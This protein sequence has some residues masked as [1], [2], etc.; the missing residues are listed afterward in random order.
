MDIRKRG[1]SADSKQHSKGDPP[2]DSDAT[3]TR[4]APCI[5]VNLRRSNGW[6]G[7]KCSPSMTSWR[8]MRRYDGQHIDQG[9]FLCHSLPRASCVRP[10][11]VSRRASSTWASAPARRQGRGIEVAQANV[12]PRGPGRAA[13]RADTRP[14]RSRTYLRGGE[15]GPSSLGLRRTV[16]G[17]ST[18][19][20]AVRTGRRRRG[21]QSAS[22]S[23]EIRMP[24]V[25]TGRTGIEGMR[26]GRR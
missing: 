20:M 14:R 11:R 9:N 25:R 22:M 15:F 19:R 23:L 12:G 26:E 5:P 24:K 2:P 18:P 3:A 8:D 1:G 4:P 17:P 13:A 6:R 21:R 10:R 16:A 7:A